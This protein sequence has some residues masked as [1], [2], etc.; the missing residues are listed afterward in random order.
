MTFV[1]TIIAIAWVFLILVVLA[2][3][4]GARI[5]SDGDD[6]APQPDQESPAA[7]PELEHVAS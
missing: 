6:G 2:F 4:R 7:S 1:F 3:L 5:A